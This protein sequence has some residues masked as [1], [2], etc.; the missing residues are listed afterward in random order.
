MDRHT[1]RL[2]LHRN[3]RAHRGAFTL[4]ELLV[5]LAILAIL[6]GLLLPSLTMARRAAETARCANNLRQVG[7]AFQTY[8]GDHGF[9]PHGWNY[10]GGPLGTD[11]VSWVYYLEE[12]M[13]VGND[14][15]G[16]GPNRGGV[17][18]CPALRRI[19]P[20]FYGFG[21]T[22]GYAANTDLLG[23]REVTSFFS[24]LQRPV[25]IDRV[26]DPSSTFL[27]VDTWPQDAF[28]W[29]DPPG[30]PAFAV[31]PEDYDGSIANSMVPYRVKQ[32]GGRANILFLDGHLATTAPGKHVD[33]KVT[34]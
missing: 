12:Y 8:A 30:H 24:I 13:P 25:A 16:I 18:A 29:Q 32:H 34:P 15:W 19:S 4:I 22:A 17:F 23:Y 33:G 2:R 1:S 14:Y 11:R 10:A 28:N 9:L 31:R 20:L 3:L 7:L 27:V 26:S 5:V 6:I 21:Y